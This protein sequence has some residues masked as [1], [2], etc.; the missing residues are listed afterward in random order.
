MT[1]MDPF[2]LIAAPGYSFDFTGNL[3][4]IPDLTNFTGS[5]VPEISGRYEGS[6]NRNLSVS[7]VGNGTISETAG[8]TA[9]VT[10]EVTGKVIAEIEIGED[11]ES[12]KPIE[13]TEGVFVSF[14]VGDVSDGD[15]FTTTLV[16][17]SDSTG[18]LSALG[19]NSFFEGDDA[20]NI[21]V[22]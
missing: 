6:A 7:I 16:A 14:E 13:L 11:Y 5:S 8:L 3:E 12:G 2:H 10:D 21:A 4:T 20:T 22:S 19:L 17:D 18:V 15:T 9:Q 1:K